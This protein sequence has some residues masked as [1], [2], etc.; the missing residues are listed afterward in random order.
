VIPSSAGV[1]S[2]D[3]ATVAQPEKDNSDF[4]RE[5]RSTWA[6]LLRKIFEIDPLLCACGARMKIVSFI[7]EPRIVDRILR[8]RESERCQAKDP[9]EPR[10]PP[11]AQ[12][13]SRP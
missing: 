6:R 2:A 12:T 10:A 7:T 11:D 1:D 8:H 13:G 4:S 5:T 3:A 9:F